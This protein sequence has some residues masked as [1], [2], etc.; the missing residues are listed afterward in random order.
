MS[1]SDSLTSR[2]VCYC[3]RN[4]ARRYLLPHCI[5]CRARQN[6]DDAHAVGVTVGAGDSFT[7]MPKFE[8]AD[9]AALIDED[10]TTATARDTAIANGS[11]NDAAMVIF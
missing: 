8:Y 5:N 2:L 1:E 4:P 3:S 10:A 7:I 6:L 9:D 11:R